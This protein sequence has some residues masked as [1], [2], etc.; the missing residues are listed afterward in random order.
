MRRF[1]N[2]SSE[3]LGNRIK[4]VILISFAVNKVAVFVTEEKQ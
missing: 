3:S 1:G 4:R 2:H